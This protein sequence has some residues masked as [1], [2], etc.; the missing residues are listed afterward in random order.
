[1]WANLRSVALAERQLLEQPSPRTTGESWCELQREHGANPERWSC[2]QGPHHSSQR[3]CTSRQQIQSGNGRRNLEKRSSSNS[4]GRRSRRAQAT[5]TGNAAAGSEG[6]TGLRKGWTAW[7]R[8]ESRSSATSLAS[9]EASKPSARR[10]TEAAHG[11][12]STRRRSRRM[13]VR[14]PLAGESMRRS[15]SR[16]RSRQR[17]LARRIV[18][19]EKTV[20]MRQTWAVD[21]AGDGHSDRQRPSVVVSQIQC[22]RYGTL[23]RVVHAGMGLSYL[24]A[25]PSRRQL[26]W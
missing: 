9:I 24:D 7:K 1:V 21:R 6:R 22:R 3:T 8:Q 4:N 25:A 2:I 15:T 20:I 5:S 10:R 13:S 16:T 18:K 14:L 11:W 12:R 19:S 17:A 23:P 26:V